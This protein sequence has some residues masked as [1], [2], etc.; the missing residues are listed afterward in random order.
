MNTLFCDKEDMT[1]VSGCELIE[2]VV[3]KDQ[4]RTLYTPVYL[5]NDRKV[6][7]IPFALWAFAEETIP[8]DYQ[9]VVI[10]EG[11]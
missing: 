8:K 9:Y 1:Y 3:L 4:S 7:V 2:F 6:A 10:H 5:K 11:N